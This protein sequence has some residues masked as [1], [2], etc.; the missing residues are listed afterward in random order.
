MAILILTGLRES[1]RGA[2]YCPSAD[3]PPGR[4]RALTVA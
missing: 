3:I 1:G 4:P 2:L